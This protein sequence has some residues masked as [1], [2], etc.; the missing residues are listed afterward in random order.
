M[1]SKKKITPKLKLPTDLYKEK[2]LKVIIGQKMKNLKKNK[3]RPVA[4][5]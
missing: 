1:M 4:P 5:T 2:I 3:L